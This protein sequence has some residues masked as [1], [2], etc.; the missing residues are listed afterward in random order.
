MNFIFFKL[1]LGVHD[2]Y[3]GGSGGGVCDTMEPIIALHAYNTE[4][5]RTSV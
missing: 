5:G 1:L 4:L 3:G 2:A